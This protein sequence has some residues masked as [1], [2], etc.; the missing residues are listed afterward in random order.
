MQA[1]LSRFGGGGEGGRETD[2]G[3]SVGQGPIKAVT[4]VPLMIMRL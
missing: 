1:S 3:V 4:R 2:G